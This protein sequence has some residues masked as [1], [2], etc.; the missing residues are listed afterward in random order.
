MFK[1]GHQLNRNTITLALLLFGYGW[2]LLTDM[3]VLDLVTHSLSLFDLQLFKGLFFVSVASSGVYALLYIRDNMIEESQQYAD[4]ILQAT[5][6]AI[7]VINSSGHIQKVNKA[8]VEKF[9]YEKRD[10]SGSSYTNLMPRSSWPAAEEEF[11]NMFQGNPAQTKE[12]TMIDKDGLEVQ[13]VVSASLLRKD[14]GEDLLVVSL[15]DITE[16]KR[17]QQKLE[18]SLNEKKALLGEVHHRVKNNL[19]VISSIAQL[20]A[21]NEDD[22]YLKQKLFGNVGRIQTMASIHE[23]LYAE[24]RFSKL[25]LDELVQK[26]ATKAKSSFNNPS[27]EDISVTVD[28]EAIALNINQAIPFALIFNEVLVNAIKHAFPENAKGKVNVELS[29]RDETVV[30][31]IRDNGIGLPEEFYSVKTMGKELIKTLTNQLEGTCLYEQHDNG[32]VFQLT[33]EKELVKGVGNAHLL[34]AS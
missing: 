23:L 25:M 20:Q 1:I 29:Q 33:F 17:I 34:K 32:T 28:T 14:M 21:F 24:E 22:A 2:V 31:V 11:R 6:V 3:I 16:Q 30:L 12:W 10:I 4:T 5:D 15:T 19:A 18:T 26:L 7:A 27:L 9:G 8:F 13:M